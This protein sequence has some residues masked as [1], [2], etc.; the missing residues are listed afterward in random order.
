MFWY[1]FCKIDFQIVVQ[2]IEKYFFENL[3][4]GCTREMYL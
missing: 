4:I 1:K 3:K 2:L